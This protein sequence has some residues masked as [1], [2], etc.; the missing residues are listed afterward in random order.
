MKLLHSITKISCVL[1]IIL[2]YN[3][4][5]LKIVKADT[6]PEGSV[7][8]LINTPHI[9]IADSKGTIHWGGD[10]RALAGKRIV[11]NM[12]TEVDVSALQKYPIGDPWLSSGLIKIGDPIYLVKWETNW[13]S[14][15]LLHIQSIKDVQIFGINTSNYGKYVL[16]QSKWE[17]KFRLQVT[18]LE[19]MALAPASEPVGADGTSPPGDTPQD[20]AKASYVDPRVLKADPIA[21]TGKFVIVWGSPQSVEISNGGTWIS[22]RAFVKSSGVPPESI[23]I[24]F[25]N[26]ENNILRSEC[27]E[28]FGVVSGIEKFKYSLTGI[29]GSSVG[30]QGFAWAP[31]AK[32]NGLCLIN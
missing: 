3:I 23:I 32:S 24:R 31:V 19:R 18:G 21:S 20:R 5:F 27:Y 12:R 10:T 22:F 17:I 11:W 16:D 28:I 26:K 8:S 4:Y 9:W 29:E 7:I 25:S 6:L 2:L 13:I 15:K 1:G 14:P 30:I